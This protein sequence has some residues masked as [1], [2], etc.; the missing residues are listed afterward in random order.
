MLRK[1]GTGLVVALV[2]LPVAAV[3]GG[4]GDAKL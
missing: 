1:L 2:A 3:C 4:K